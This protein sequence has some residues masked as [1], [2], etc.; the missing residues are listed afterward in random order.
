MED[1]CNFY[2]LNGSRNA[3]S[4]WLPLHRWW[5]AGLWG[6]HPDTYTIQLGVSLRHHPTHHTYD[7]KVAW[8]KDALL[9][10]SAR[11]RY[12]NQDLLTWRWHFFLASNA[13]RAAVLAVYPFVCVVCGGKWKNAVSYA[14]HCEAKSYREKH[15][16][17]PVAAWWFVGVETDNIPQMPTEELP[18]IE[19]KSKD[20]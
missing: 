16:D 18:K 10:D 15:E 3:L 1:I 20:T 17:V 12:P 2:D 9:R 6:L 14:G 8:C 7:G 4:I 13:K 19:E 5:D 11:H